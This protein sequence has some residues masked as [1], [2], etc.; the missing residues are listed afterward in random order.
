MSKE[1]CIANICK[2][3]EK[4]ELGRERRIAAMSMLIGVSNCFC[5]K[6]K[7]MSRKYYDIELNQKITETII[8]L[9]DK[10]KAN[11]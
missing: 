1:F 8:K 10:R 11:I 3:V 2:E 5:E 9:M 7:E 6:C 4:H